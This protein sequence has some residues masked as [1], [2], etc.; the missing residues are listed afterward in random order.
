MKA[1]IVLGFIPK[2]IEDFVYVF[3]YEDLTVLYFVD[4]MVST[5]FSKDGVPV[6]AP[7]YTDIEVATPGGVS[8]SYS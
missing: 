1:L 2:E 5:V 3:Q 6:T 7:L 4:D 8:V